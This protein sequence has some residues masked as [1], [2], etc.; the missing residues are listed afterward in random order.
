MDVNQNAVILWRRLIAVRS[1]YQQVQ[2]LPTEISRAVSSVTGVTHSS[3]LDEYP[4]PEEEDFLKRLEGNFAV[5]EEELATCLREEVVRSVQGS[6]SPK[7]L[8]LLRSLEQQAFDDLEKLD[9]GTSKAEA[10]LLA[11]RDQFYYNFTA[12]YSVAAYFADSLE[13]TRRL[14]IGDWKQLMREKKAQGSQYDTLIFWRQ[15]QDGRINAERFRF[16]ESA[17]IT[18][19]RDLEAEIIRTFRRPLHP[20]HD[21]WFI[22]KCSALEHH[23]RSYID[24]ALDEILESFESTGYERDFGNFPNGGMVLGTAFGAYALARFGRIS[25]H[26]NA[27]DKALNWLVGQ[28]HPS[29]AWGHIELD[30]AKTTYHPDIWVTLVVLEALRLAHFEAQHTI[31]SGVS[32]LLAQQHTDGAW[33]GEK[34]PV[35]SDA[36]TLAIFE[37]LQDAS[38]G[39]V[40]GQPLNQLGHD[41]LQRSREFLLEDRANSLRLAVM[42]AH[43]G[44][45]MLLYSWLGALNIRT[46]DNNASLGVRIATKKIREAFYTKKRLNQGH[47]MPYESEIERLAYFRDEVVHKGAAVPAQEGFHLIGCIMKFVKWAENELEAVV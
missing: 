23:I 44:L 17:E 31:A 28:Q 15:G 21:L 40:K 38:A 34:A 13:E 9:M 1:I 30:K 8:S 37:Y 2:R 18:D 3:L 25:I 19:F 27:R 14:I 36:L 47:L 11:H 45:E 29:G 6:H 16:L 20:I 12:S 10:F 33:Y 24:V 43:Q 39:A 26:R 35:P 4:N 41:L 7:L 22:G 46:I 32:W 42:T 5:F